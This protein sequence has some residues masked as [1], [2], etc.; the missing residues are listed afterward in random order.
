MRFEEE[1]ITIPKIDIYE[2]ANLSD[3]HLTKNGDMKKSKD[4][5]IIPLPLNKDQ[6]Q[7]RSNLDITSHNLIQNPG[8]ESY[9]YNAGEH[10][11]AKKSEEEKYTPVITS[12]MTGNCSTL[13]AKLRTV[14]PAK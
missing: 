14:T 10:S 9:P 3:V 4:I 11:T 13:C 8:Y 7:S 1:K 12:V 2:S 5:M 6:E